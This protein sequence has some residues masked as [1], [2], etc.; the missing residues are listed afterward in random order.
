MSLEVMSGY[1]ISLNGF[2]GFFAIILRLDFLV[3]FILVSED[4][5]VDV[6]R[7]TGLNTY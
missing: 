7:G 1:T 3:D 4:V 2:E 5:V 6:E